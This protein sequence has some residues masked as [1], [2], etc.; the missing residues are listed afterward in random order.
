MS[1]QVSTRLLATQ[2][3]TRLLELVAQGHER[4]FDALVLRY[5]RPLLAYCRRLGLADSRAEDA[6]Q[7][8]LL[9]AWLA[10][11]RG[12]EVR[13]LR[14]WLYRIVHNTALNLLRS[15][16]EDGWPIVE[17]G[18]VAVAVESGAEGR[19]AARQ[20]LSDVAALPPMQRDV[21]LMSA[22]AG[23]SHEEVASALGIT[24]GAVRGLLYRARTTLRGAAAALTPPPLLSWAVGSAGRAAP[25][26]A[27][28]AAVSGATGGGDFGAL[29]LKGTAV[30]FTAAL[31]TGAVLVP[32]HRHEAHAQTR[33]ALP[34]TP[35][36]AVGQAIAPA[37]VVRL[38]AQ[39]GPTQS[40]A[41]PAGTSLR[42]AAP[43]GS[44]TPRGQSDTLP[45]DLPAGA[46]SEGS[47]G[48]GVGGAT[49]T[50]S[51]EGEVRTASAGH[52]EE[53]PDSG[54]PA[55]SPNGSPGTVTPSAEPP[56]GGSGPP[57]TE[58]QAA[59]ERREHE[60]EQARELREREAEAARER[61]EHE[62]EQAREL[63]VREAEVARGLL[64]GH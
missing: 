5:R 16:R 49:P 11:Q 50:A 3:D 21:I 12:T 31:A 38:A 15:T 48:A 1:P 22:V 24:D 57:E 60:E 27:R 55:P 2:S 58:S 44:A 8:A 52:P 9:K 23:R 18:A 54:A 46:P 17:G 64:P 26:A 43:R 56:A 19:I 61:R 36:G 40:T 39:V 53:A 10:L 59:R 45:S 34:G 25:S 7:Q 30:A 47:R 37:F 35:R 33:A 51:G 13:E 63:E 29:I 62:E 20:A 41:G 28:I 42:A 4:A 14:P 32:N 6:L